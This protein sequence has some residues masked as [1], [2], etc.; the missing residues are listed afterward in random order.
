M[1]DSLSENGDNVVQTTR[2]SGHSKKGTKKHAR[3]CQAK[4][5]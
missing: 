4:K 2:R 1:K 5:K 3:A